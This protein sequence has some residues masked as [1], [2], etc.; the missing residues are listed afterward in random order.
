MILEL[1][2]SSKAAACLEILISPGWWQPPE[3]L[4]MMLTNLYMVSFR[5][6]WLKGQHPSKSYRLKTVMTLEGQPWP[7]ASL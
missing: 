5:T 4:V 2:V 6:L 3:L 1:S 7:N